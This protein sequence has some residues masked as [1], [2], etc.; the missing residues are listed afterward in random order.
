MGSS[1]VA[2]PDQRAHPKRGDDSSRHAK[3][4]STRGREQRE[5][6]LKGLKTFPGASLFVLFL[7][8]TNR[9]S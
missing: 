3:E 1:G 4:T 8:L 6:Q 2:D 9:A 5:L 7:S